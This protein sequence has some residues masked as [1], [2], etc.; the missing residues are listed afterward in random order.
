M[1]T[2]GNMMRPRTVTVVLLLLCSLCFPAFGTQDRKE[3]RVLTWNILH[4]GRADGED[5]GPQRVIDIIRKSGADIVALQETYGSGAFL[6]KELQYAFH[7]RGSNVSLL[8][9]YPV[10]EDISVYEEFNCVGALIQL[11]DGTRVAAYSVWLPYDNEIWE[12]GTRTPGDAEQIQGACRSSAIKINLIRAEISKRLSNKRYANVPIILA[13][14]FNSMSHLDYTQVARDQYHTVIRGE[15]SRSLVD[16]GWRD[17][18]RENHPSIRRVNDR[19]WSPRHSKQEQDR[20]DFIYYKGNSIRATESKIIDSHPVKFPSD[21][22]AVLSVF[23]PNQERTESTRIHVATYNIRRGLG[24]DNRTDL[25]RASGVLKEL[26]P[27][28]IALQE[29][30]FLTQRSGRVNQAAQLGN[31]LGMHAAFGQFMPYDSGYYGIGVLS[32]YPIVDTR[33]IHLPDGN[34]PRIA[35]AVDVLLPNDQ[36]IIVIAVHF[37][38]VNDDVFRY[39]QAQ[40]VADWIDQQSNPCI[41]MGDFNDTPE[42]RTLR[43]FEDRAVE[44]KKPALNRFTFSSTA[45][46]TEIDFIFGAPPSRWDVGPARVTNDPLSS[47]HFPV[48]AFLQLRANTASD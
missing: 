24:T 33:S 13:G 44:A 45:P 8:S 2:T 22:A 43:L 25:S 9:R 42:S 34:E 35:L 11:P 1:R 12:Q 4:G 23:E 41:L 29:V 18:Y 14:D 48:D 6:S 37:D 5:V 40:V 32:R 19:T 26:A 46:Y 38:W 7:P 36:R 20:I 10:I 31:Q 15:T 21:H 39:A 27:D 3:F 17:S 30:D 47:D 28:I 16:H